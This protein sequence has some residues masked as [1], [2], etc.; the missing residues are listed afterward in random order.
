MQ[1]LL[2]L[3]MLPPQMNLY[4]PSKQEAADLLTTPTRFRGM[5]VSGNAL[6]PAVLLEQALAAEGGDWR[7]PRLFVDEGIGQ[8]VG[9]GGFKSAP[10]ERRVEIGYGV[11]PACQ[12]RGYATAGVHLLVAQAFSSGLV[13]EVCAETALDNAVSQRVLEKVGFSMEGS[14]QDEDGPVK[15]WAIKRCPHH[16]LRASP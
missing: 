8:V 11:A 14:G 9:S 7:M 10:R 2:G 16:A 4:I 5:L 12:G 6:P 13:D 15:L 3:D 1:T